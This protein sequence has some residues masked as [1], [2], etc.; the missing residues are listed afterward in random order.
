M[1]T[2]YIN[3]WTED[4][5]FCMMVWDEDELDEEVTLTGQSPVLLQHMT[6]LYT[7]LEEKQTERLHEFNR[8]LAFLSER[9]LKPFA[10]QIDT[11]TLI[12]ITVTTDLIKAPFDLLLHRDQHLF[13]QRPVCYQIDIGLVDNEPEFQIESALVLADLSADPERACAE[14]AESIHGSFYAEGED[15][16]VAMLE[17]YGQDVDMIVVSACCSTT[18][19][20]N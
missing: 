8:S 1:S 6:T 15:A 3:Y 10:Q 2:L 20:S 11:H 17:E 9:L 5:D 4:D 7:I 14:V 13:L 16:I 18:K 12:R 19:R